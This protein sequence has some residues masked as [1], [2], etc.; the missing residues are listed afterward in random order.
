MTKNIFL[1]M[2]ILTTAIVSCES[3]G[4]SVRTESV[5]SVDVPD[6]KKIVICVIKF[7]D[8]S[9]K[10]K[11]FAPWTMGIPDMIMESLGAIP[12]YKVLSRE[13]IQTHVIREQ[14]FQLLGLTDSESA[15]KTGNI[16][17][18]QYV[19]AGSFSVF[20][21]SLTVN[22][23]VISVKTGQIVVQA[24]SRDSID[25][26][27]KCQNDLAIKITRSMNLFM[28]P[29]SQSRLLARYDTKIREASLE[30]YKG[31][32]K[33]EEI[34]ILKKKGETQKAKQLIEEARQ[35]FKKAV[36]LD[37]KYEKA[38]RNLSKYVLGSP[39]TL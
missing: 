38:K 36:E 27:F 2:I 26:F 30:N 39:M 18:A 28:S 21:E 1:S 29:E 6:N 5:I 12:Y 37:Q 16:L 35:D 31:E 11:D 10:T 17:N 4:G 14:E 9:I 13:Y 33:A 19:V 25:N 24:S 34:L 22:A 32:V 8:Q 15:V 7:E 23:K 3:A 20:R